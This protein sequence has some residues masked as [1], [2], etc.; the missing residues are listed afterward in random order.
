MLTAEC[1]VDVEAL[2]RLVA[3]RDAK[4]DAR[5]KKLLDMWPKTKGGVLRGRIRREDPRQGDPHGAHVDVA[6]R[7]E[8][9]QGSAARV[10][11]RRRDPALAAR[12][13]VPGSF[14]FTAGVFAFKRE[15]EDPTRMF[16]G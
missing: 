12:E 5:A 10:R 9:P 16:A 1:K 4:L 13:N 14:P 11:G 15:N 8:D 6:V 7:H 2:D 3:D